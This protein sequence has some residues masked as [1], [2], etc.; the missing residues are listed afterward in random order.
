MI[1]VTIRLPDDLAQE[2]KA[3]GLLRDEAI[4]SLLREALRQRQLD[5]LFTTLASSPPSSRN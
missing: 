2:A 1:T 5:E 3:A 4:E